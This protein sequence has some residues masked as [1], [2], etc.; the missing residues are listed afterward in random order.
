MRSIKKLTIYALVL[1]LATLPAINPWSKEIVHAAEGVP[2]LLITEIVPKSAGNGQPYEYVELYNNT[3][4]DI[5]LNNYQLQYFTTNM[6][7]AAN[8]WKILGKKIEARSTLVLWLIKLDFPNVTLNEFNENYGTD[9]TDDQIY[10]VNLTTAAQ[11][12]H[13]TA[14]RKV[15]IAGADGIVISQV[16]YNDQGSTDGDTN[17]S[18]IYELPASGNEMMRLRNNEIPTPGSL[19][20]D[21]LEGPM[22]PTGLT[23]EAGDTSVQLSW[24]PHNPEPASYNI[25]QL[26]STEPVTVTGSTYSYT[27]TG[28]VNGVTYRYRITAVDE[29]GLESPA[30]AP[31]SVTPLG[32]IDLEYPNAPEGLQ[33]EPGPNFVYLSWNEKE[34][35]NVTGYNIYKDGLFYR[36]V[37]SPSNGLT[38]TQ[39][40]LGQKYS[41][42]VKAVNIAGIESEESATLEATPTYGMMITEL[43]PD[44]DNY[45]SYDAYEYIELY[46]ASDKA[47]DLLGY[48]VKSGSWSYSFDQ[49]VIVQPWETELLWTRR[50]EVASLSLEGF[51]HYYFSAYES[52]YLPSDKMHIIENVGGLVNTGNQTVTVQDAHGNEVS[53]ASYNG[54]VDTSLG[55]SVM[56]SYPSSGGTVM[57]ILDGQ[58]KPT[59]GWLVYGQ[60]PAKMIQNTL[61]PHAPMQLTA[62]PGEDSV[63]LSWSPNAEM[64]VLG[65]RVYK[66]GIL[67]ASIPASQHSFTVYE[68]VRNTEYSFEVT[69]Y[70]TS[71]L[72]SVKSASVLAKPIH[73]KLTQQERTVNPRDAAY[74]S[75]WNV[76]KDGPIIAGLAEEMVPQGLG[77]APD[78]NWLLTVYYTTDERPGVLSVTDAKTGS[79]IKSVAMYQE[80]GT[81]Y[82]GHAGGVSISKNYVWISSEGYLYQMNL[83]ELVNAVDQGEIQF[84][85]RVR[86]AVDSAFSTYSDG[87]IWVGEFYESASYPTIASHHLKNRD[88]DQYYAWLAG[89]VLDEQTDTIKAANWDGDLQHQ[90][91]PD[92]LLSIPEKIQ[93]VVVQDDTIY[94]SSSYGRNKDS[95]LYRFNNPIEEAP[96][97]TGLVGQANVPL[98]FL[99]G[100]SAKSRN[101]T[102]TAVPMTENIASIDNQ[103][104]VLLESGA[105]KYRYT[106]TYIMDR[107][108]VID[109]EMWDSYGT[110]SIHGTPS[111]MHTGDSV[112]AS[113]K[114]LFGLAESLDVTSDYT[115]ESSN[116]V[117]ADVTAEGRITAKAVGN[118]VITATSNYSIVT[119]NLQVES[120]PTEG[121]GSGNGSNNGSDSGGNHDDNI[122]GTDNNTSGGA[123]SKES[124]IKL[125]SEEQAKVNE[126]LLQR[127][128][129]LQATL[130]PLADSIRFDASNGPQKVDIPVKSQVPSGIPV[131]VY[132]IDSNG[133]LTYV[134]G[135]L[136]KDSISI[137]LTE[138]GIYVVL[139]FDKRFAD[140]TD[141]YFAYDAIRLL[142]AMQIINGKN[143]KDFAPK[144]QVSRAE[145]I[146]MLVRTLGLK[147]TSTTQ[148]FADIRAD[149]WYAKAVIAAKEAGLTSGVNDNS[150]APNATVSR[151]QMASFLLRAYEIKMKKS[152]P[153]GGSIPFKDIDEVSTWAKDDLGAA[154]SLGLVSGRNHDKYV[155]QDRTTRAEAAQAI[156]NL[157]SLLK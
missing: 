155:P 99:D 21:Q 71:D 103:L 24:T 46:N 75:L 145:F 79:L 149:A 38:V 125:D 17:K 117:T 26:G 31:I 156:Y 111:V 28:L 27:A 118:T 77:Y 138:S 76:S 14:L 43:V 132:K 137:E 40:N 152:A 54:A 47:V 106:T 3:S 98:W 107:M 20:N 82:L 64:D 62:V 34:E 11:G 48:T 102:L 22:E 86:V 90:A 142:S 37:G 128:Q 50:A 97:G 2:N 4:M 39:L 66:E 96:H 135:A 10:R 112:Q 151:E 134:G 157:L 115:F 5:D 101:A 92:Y 9:L 41:F 93:G 83:S 121:N 84:T 146:A 143:E 81:P 59:P 63:Q 129:T 122:G 113:V 89:Y 78:Q 94:L 44:T 55:T 127:S 68:L 70:N 53:K 23:A 154:Y 60:A 126:I 105:N 119:L 140:V 52:K 15:A 12:L 33:A 120:K 1:I 61:P 136:N 88:N 6:D 7:K 18:V 58:Q 124:V 30:S 51:N 114:Q 45:A 73:Q 85:S 32:A 141:S 110:F 104:Y 150:F 67:E 131:G 144:Q 13:D 148:S 153:T 56:F 16:M 74:Q 130:L 80:D 8:T 100:Q 72:E 49:S 36:T 91:V 35:A 133:S 19:S 69:A 147:A 116:T 123:T 57:S 65:Y 29:S 139:S 109:M 95:I 108:L 87:V 42:E 25:Y